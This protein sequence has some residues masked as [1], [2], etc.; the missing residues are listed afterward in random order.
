MLQL[1]SRWRWAPEFACLSVGWRNASGQ[2]RTGGHP[3]SGAV[4]GPRMRWAGVII[5][6]WWENLNSSVA[7]QRRPRPAPATAP[8][9]SPPTGC[10]MGYR[11]FPCHSRP[12]RWVISR[13]TCLRAVTKRPRGPCI[14]IQASSAGQRWGPVAQERDHHRARDCA[15]WRSVC[16]AGWRLGRRTEIWQ[17]DRGLT[18]GVAVGMNRRGRRRGEGGLGEA[19]S[20]GRMKGGRPFVV[21]RLSLA[22]HLSQARRADRESLVTPGGACG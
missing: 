15:L 6:R 9:R 20:V 12:M 7:P 10:S 4:H 22:V 5:G 13:R 19:T 18:G 21:G 3:L 1:V 17:G 8:R 2:R 16:W 14:E 11:Q